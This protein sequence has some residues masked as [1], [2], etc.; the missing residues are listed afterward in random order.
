MRKE[1]DI[2]IG[3]AGH[4]ALVAACYLALA[5]KKVK[6]LEKEPSPGGAAV[7]KKVFPD[8]EANL[9][10]YAYLV[11]LFPEKIRKD[12]ELGFKLLP[13]T[14]SSYTA[15]SDDP[16]Q[17]LLLPK[18]E[19]FSAIKS[20]AGVHEAKAYLEMQQQVS[21]FVKEVSPSLLMPLQSKEYWIEKFRNNRTIWD[22]LVEKPLGE[23]FNTY[24]ENDILKGLLFTDAK[25]G[26]FTYSMDP[27]LLQNRTYLYHVLGHDWRVPEG[28]MQA[29]TSSLYN[30]ALNLG[31]EFN[32]NETV[33][34]VEF[35]SPLL[36]RT[37]KGIYQPNYYLSN[38]SL[39][40]HADPG[41]AFKIN[42]LLKK[43][44]VLKNKSV[45]PQEAFKGTFHVHQSFEEMDKSYF[46]V[47]AGKLPKPIGFEM[48]CHTLTDPSILS[49]DLQKLGFQTIT[50]FGIDLAYHLF[51]RDNEQRKKEVLDHILNAISELTEEPIS[52]YLAIDS[53]G[54]PC[55]EY[56]SAMDLENELGLPKGNIFQ[57]DL[58][59]FYSEDKLWGT[60]TDHPQVFLA[61]SSALRG[62][63]VSGIAGHNAAMAVLEK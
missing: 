32:F 21:E 7:S 30:R 61:G 27:S 41:T 43:L 24:L 45:S 58:S 31:V 22:F 8:F 54:K 55:I 46:S 9:S 6:V 18:G 51:E 37:S 16:T 10:R 50:I 3:G 14:I 4:N 47:C 28:G 44:P 17:G 48:Y 33:E 39:E 12:L 52:H 5:G 23:F 15:F 56:K 35:Q 11:S 42:L 2:L 63:A 57:N 20:W 40:S 19:E 29:V 59:W 62:G 13:R 34:E 60:E 53:S 26:A 49:T 36:I 38:K 1:V 25:I